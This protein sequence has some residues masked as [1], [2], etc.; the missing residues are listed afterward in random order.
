MSRSLTPYLQQR[1][2]QLHADIAALR[3]R[4]AEA[5]RQLALAE[6]YVVAGLSSDVEPLA[7]ARNHAAELE[8]ELALLLRL[9]RAIHVESGA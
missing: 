3:P 1:S 6:A 8:H 7:A 5:R 2:Q 9:A 4:L